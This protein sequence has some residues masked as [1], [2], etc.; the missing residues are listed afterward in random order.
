MYTGKG[1][2]ACAGIT[3]GKV[4]HIKT[5]EVVE[6]D[7][8]CLSVEQELELFEGALSKAATELDRLIEKAREEIG[9]EQA[10]IFEIHRMMLEDPDIC[11]NI[12]DRIKKGGINAADAAVSVG[13]EQA[14]DFEALD[15]PYMR[16]RAADVKDVTGRIARILRGG[17]TVELTEA[18]VIV[19]DDLQP[20][21]TVALD[22]S[23]ILGFVLRH[24]TQN[25]HASI[26]ARTMNIPLIINSNLPSSLDG[27][28]KAATESEEAMD[29]T[30]HTIGLD[31]VKGEF[32]IDPDHSTITK[33]MA[34]KDAFEQ[35]RIRQLALRGQPGISKTGHRVYTFANIGQP[36]DVEQVLENDGEGIGLFRSEFLYLGRSDPPSEEE[37]FK[38]YAKVAS[39]MNGRLVIIRTLDIGADKQVDYFDLP[40]EENPALGLRALRICLTKPEI[41]KTQLR[42]IYRAAARG[43]IAMMFPMVTRLKEIEQAKAICAEVVAEL[44][45]ENI[46]YGEPKVGIMIETP[47]AA[48]L[49]RQLAEHVDFFSVGTNDLNQ[50]TTAC[51]RQNQNLGDFYDPHHE[52]VLELLRQIASNA[53][54]AGITAGICGEL[55]ADPELTD[56]FIEMG[57][58]ELSVSPGAVLALRER[59]RNSEAVCLSSLKNPKISLDPVKKIH[60]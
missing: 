22:R 34:A 18:C 45:S 12:R 49:S 14:A 46:E 42:A 17:E 59:V 33:L 29:L 11:D 25:S 30:G 16:E 32:F 54:A 38:A 9:D 2:C 44:K 37:Q 58:D 1:R 43:N 6:S 15:D 8:D 26:L 36:D 10:E 40:H 51:D 5:P 31:A 56:K 28:G 19:A 20:S 57:Y 27:D 24:G 3:F 35:Q 41:F 4:L 48:V 52:A 60:S 53:H 55:A 21:Q 39:A 7:R 23:L 50:Y 47:A 13:K